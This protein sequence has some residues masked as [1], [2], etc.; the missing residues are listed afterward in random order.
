M[1]RNV[2]QECDTDR[3]A[4]ALEG[5]LTRTCEVCSPSGIP[6]QRAVRAGS[7]LAYSL[8]VLPDDKGTYLISPW[9]QCGRRCKVRQG[10]VALLRGEGWG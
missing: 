4:A 8:R 9:R 2:A 5:A 3:S 7:T 6:E 10:G 1:E